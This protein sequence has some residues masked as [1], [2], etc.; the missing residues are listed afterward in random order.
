MIWPWQQET[1]G[2]HVFDKQND[3]AIHT[4]SHNREQTYAYKTDGPLSNDLFR[5]TQIIIA[6]SN[7]HTF[8][9]TQ[10]RCWVTFSYAKLFNLLTYIFY[11]TLFTNDSFIP[12]HK[13]HV[14]YI[15][16]SHSKIVK[17]L[18]RPFRNSLNLTRIAKWGNRGRG[19]PPLTYT[20]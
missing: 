4:Y 7:D 13:E 1:T 16:F 2:G 19:E 8:Q 3:E 9:M 14:T 18:F 15:T 10:S 11:L 12:Y 5:I 20:L 6:R 17:T